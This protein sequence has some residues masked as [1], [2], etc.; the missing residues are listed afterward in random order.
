MSEL[1]GSRSAARGRRARRADNPRK[2]RVNLSYN[3]TEY[4]LLRMAAG[5]EGLT[6]GAYV[7]HA[8]LAVAKGD[9][10]PLPVNERE[11]LR[12]LAQTRVALN[13]I[14]TNLN[15]IAHVLN[16]EGKATPEQLAA[17]LSRVEAAVERLDAASIELLGRA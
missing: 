13:R 7:A 8:A 12:E 16:A 1:N 10:L 5:R 9:V 14:G 11:R 15:Q 6:V 4:E 2:K 3:S 17:V